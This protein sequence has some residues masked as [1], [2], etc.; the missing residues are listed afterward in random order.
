MMRI[1][2][3]GVGAMGCLFGAR[4]SPHA[5]VTLFGRW[6]E[7][8]AA[9]RAAPLRLIGLD[10]SEQLVQITVTDDPT[11]I[12]EVDAALVLTKSG[13]TLRAAQVLAGLIRPDG[14]VITLQNGIGNLEMLASVLGPE[15]VTQGVTM[16]GAATDGPGVVRIGGEG[17]TYLGIHSTAPQV[18][19]E[20][21]DLL[22]AAGFETHRSDDLRGL[23][24]GKLA[25][26]AAINPLTAL[27]GVP[28]GAL[29]ESRWA[30]DLMRE[31]VQEVEIVAAVKGIRLPFDDPAQRVEE[32]ARATARNRSSMLQDILRGAETEIEVISGAVVRL[33]HEVNVPTPVNALLY[34]LV[35]ALEDQRRWTGGA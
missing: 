9:L 27:L 19:D 22:T 32:V 13:G 5:E 34:R 20:V 8:I 11:T 2:I 17:P 24:W 18:M 14:V 7:Q 21:A 12:G 29:L 26:N 6:P 10:E 35:K 25:V 33:G 16:M 28:N 4:L 23:V 31:A 3:A 15:R 30:R 1:A